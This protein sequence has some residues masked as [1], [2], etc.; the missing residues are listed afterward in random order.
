[1]GNTGRGSPSRLVEAASCLAVVGD[2]VFA[3]DHMAD[4]AMAASVDDHRP[5]CKRG[6]PDVRC[7]RG[8]A[9]NHHRHRRGRCRSSAISPRTR[10]LPADRGLVVDAE[11]ESPGLAAFGAKALPAGAALRSRGPLLWRGGAV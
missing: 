2:V 5:G 8:A 7:C 9:G 10:S 11:T 4:I 3:A 6:S 1:V